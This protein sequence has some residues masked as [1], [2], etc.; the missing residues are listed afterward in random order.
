M[1]RSTHCAIIGAGITGLTAAY[2]LAKA[3]WRATVFER[4]PDAGGL[5]ATFEVGGE[6]LECFYHH[7]FT[8]DTDYVEL[9]TELGLGD[10]IEWLPSRMGIYAAGR[11]WD[12]GTPA[13][14]LRFAPLPWLDKIRFALS[15]LYLRHRDNLAE[16]EGVTARDWVVRH[17]GRRCWEVV[18]SP[19]MRQKFADRAERVSMAW[20][21]RKL[22]LRGRSRTRSGLGESLG[23]MRG[24]FGRLVDVLRERLTG[25]GVELRLACPVRRLRPIEGG[26]ETG[27]RG[28]VERFDVALFTASPQELR[29]VTRDVAGDGPDADVGPEA[30]GALCVALELDRQ[31]SPYYWLN[32]AD[33]ACPF[34]GVIE[35]TNYV[36]AERYGGRHVAYLSKYVLPDHPLWRARDD[37]VWETYRPWL[38]RVLPGFDESAILA[39]HTFRAAY[40][41]PIVP[42]FYSRLVPPFDTSLPRVHHACMAQ[43]YPEDRGQNYAVRSGRAAAEKL[44]LRYG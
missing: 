24:S 34:G 41:Q 33:A 17:A 38:G 2:R 30:T 7:L 42:R 31:V 29:A 13:S 39:R 43:I 26:V 6:R 5:V 36:P 25:L 14:L 18:W 19:L 8:S 12:F 10:E 3:G 20:L 15:T 23:Y 4:Y 1:G 44:L 22:F 32:V 11:L 37:E 35:H 9:A 28:G 40:A 27:V 16:F 21:W